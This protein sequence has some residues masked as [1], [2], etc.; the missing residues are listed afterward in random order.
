MD[1]KTIAVGFTKDADG[2]LKSGTYDGMSLD[3][4]R[5]AGWR[6]ISY[7]PIENG[8]VWQVILEKGPEPPV[9]NA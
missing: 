9:G 2:T 7:H 3:D 1:R 6:P 4:M 5:G 8:A